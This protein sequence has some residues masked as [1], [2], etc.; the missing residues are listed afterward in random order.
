MFTVESLANAT[1]LTIPFIRKCL[2]SMDTILKPHYKK[3]EFN[4]ITFDQS[5]YVIFLKIKQL[6]EHGLLMGN[7]KANLEKQLRDGKTTTIDDS[8]DCVNTIESPLNSM[9]FDLSIVNKLIDEKEARIKE[10]AESQQRITE[11]EN[12]SEHLKGQLLLLTDGRSPEECRMEKERIKWLLREI[13]NLEGIF[14]IV[15]YFKRKKLYKE[16]K[17]LMTK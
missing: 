4:R 16:L 2:K 15:N 11:L 9:S 1:G 13:Q 7:I 12:L 10:R 14:S 5:A 3:G 8:T 6:K 17:D